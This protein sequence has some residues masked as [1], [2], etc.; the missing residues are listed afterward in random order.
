METINNIELSDKSV[1]PDETV[2]K[3][4]PGRS[5]QSYCALLALFDQNE[6]HYEWRYYMGKVMQ[7]KIQTK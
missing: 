6:M 7:F 1:Y 5:Y 2:L 4:V 3:T